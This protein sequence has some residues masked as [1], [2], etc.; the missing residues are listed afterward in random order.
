MPRPDCGG[1]STW[2]SVCQR[3]GLHPE[4]RPGERATSPFRSGDAGKAW[5]QGLALPRSPVPFL[6]FLAGFS[7]APGGQAAA[8]PPTA[9]AERV[10]LPGTWGE[11]PASAPPPALPGAP[12]PAPP[13]TVE[14]G[15]GVRQSGWAEA[16]L[17][18]PAQRPAPGGSHPLL[19]TLRRG[20]LEEAQRGDGRPGWHLMTSLQ[21]RLRLRRVCT[22]CVVLNE[23]RPR[24]AGKKMSHRSG[25]NEFLSLTSPSSHAQ[26]RERQICTGRLRQPGAR[27]TAADGRGQ[28]RRLGTAGYKTGRGQFQE[29]VNYHKRIR[30]KQKT[31]ESRR[32]RGRPH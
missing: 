12:P 20:V 16:S 28:G 25:R 2:A 18:G 14:S 23:K 32:R 4:R 21:P 30:R 31:A 9:Q 15:V 29:N 7:M 24:A 19:Q 8:G 11:G 13:W 17:R 1:G 27:D 26:S 10:Q 6:L 22:L 5:A 3:S